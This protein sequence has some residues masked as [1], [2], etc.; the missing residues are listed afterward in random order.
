MI[1]CVVFDFDGTLVQ[2]NAVKRRSFHEAAALL[3]PVSDIVDRVLAE[4]AGDRYVLTRAI[5]ERARAARRLVIADV[6]SLPETLALRYTQLCDDAIAS[7][8][9]VPG[10]IE[11]LEELHGEGRALF[12]NSATPPAPLASAVRR[13]GL[14]RYF[15]AVWGNERSKVEN[16]QAAMVLAAAEAAETAFVGDGEPDRAAAAGV[17]C[18]FVGVLNAYTDFQRPATHVLRELGALPRLLREIA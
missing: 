5:V 8:P 4:C 7:A 6:P 1:R 11:M 3:G 12:I 18:H 15:R 14:G 10:A 16:L 2:S 9:F 13:R 17:G